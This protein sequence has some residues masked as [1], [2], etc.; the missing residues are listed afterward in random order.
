MRRLPPRRDG[1][2]CYRKTALRD[3][4]STQNLESEPYRMV[5][6]SS[7][8]LGFRRSLQRLTRSVDARWM[9]QHDIRWCRLYS[10]YRESGCPPVP[11]WEPYLAT[12][13]RPH[14]R[15]AGHLGFCSRFMSL[16]PVVAAFHKRRPLCLSVTASSASARCWVSLGLPGQRSRS[17]S[18]R[19]FG[20]DRRRYRVRYLA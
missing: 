18:R 19:S 11:A 6:G 4:H 17:R 3:R 20:A 2:R 13:D 16:M 14:A 10:A 12:S 15:T 9:S 8:T 7:G 1:P 5:L